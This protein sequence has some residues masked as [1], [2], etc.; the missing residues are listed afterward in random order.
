MKNT[1][2]LTPGSKSHTTSARAA[3]RAT[4]GPAALTLEKLRQFARTYYPVQA[5]CTGIILN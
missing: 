3:A 1:F 2:T 5:T 4:K